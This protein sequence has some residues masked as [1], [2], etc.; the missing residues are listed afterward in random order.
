M[1][2]VKRYAMHDRS[3]QGR[4]HPEVSHPYRSEFQRDRD[5]IVHTKA[6]RRLEKKT[7]VFAPDHSD[8]FRN[9]LTHTIEVSQISRTLGSALELNQNLCEALAL[10]HDMGHPPFGHEGERVLNQIMEGF[11]SGFDHN[12]HALRIV[13]DFE[14]RYVSFAGLNLT[15]EVR[16]GIVK[17][18]RD[19]DCPDQAYL[20]IS[21]YHLG[22]K[23][24]LEAQLI[25]LA[26]EIAY[27]AADLDDGFDS[28]LLERDQIL[29]QVEL[30]RELYDSVPTDFRRA[31]PR[32]LIF[33]L[34][35]RI[36]DCMATD[37]VRNTQLCLEQNG[38]K[39]LE[40]VRDFPRRLVAFDLEMVAKKDQL[41]KFLHRN[42]YEHP[43][44]QVARRS[45]QHL[46][47]MVFHFY[48]DDPRRLPRKHQRRTE[49]WG[50]P[51]VVCDYVAGM[52]D[53]FAQSCYEQIKGPL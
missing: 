2:T 32:L 12:L 22:R 27:N 50:V 18:S 44:L 47:T 35:K 46:L 31:R 20:D 48:L 15:F 45:A 3:S 26:D 37:L 5:R 14:E 21:E 38:I 8:H 53:P 19:F 41:K 10:S 34:V 43:T 7:Q 42:L 13:E 9:R 6:F 52:T 28:G 29:D 23:P 33:E 17:H 30:C 1:I 25:D 11:Q 16:E 4:R 24:P 39:R 40:D 36:I 49:M 51:R